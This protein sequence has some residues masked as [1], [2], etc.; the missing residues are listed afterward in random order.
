[1]AASINDLYPEYLGKDTRTLMLYRVALIKEILLE[2]DPNAVTDPSELLAANPCLACLSPT[3][4]AIVEVILL[5]GILDTGI[6]VAIPGIYDETT[7]VIVGGVPTVVPS[8]DVA[9]CIMN[10]GTL[11]LYYQGAWH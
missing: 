8:G 1:M 2:L 10:D 7:G 9:L 11:F 5:Q 4:L 6:N 3:Q